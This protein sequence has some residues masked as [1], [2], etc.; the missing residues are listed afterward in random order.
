MKGAII[1]DVCGSVYEFSPPNG[2]NFKLFSIHSQFT[3]DTV[4]TIAIADALLNKKSFKSVLREYG[5]RYKTSYGASFHR[6]LK[7]EDSSPY[8]SYGNGSAMRVSPVAY[9]A[10]DEEHLLDLAKQTA[11]VTH[12]HKEGIKGAQAVAL[13]I[14]L[15]LH[16]Y[17]KED[18]KKRIENKFKYDLSRTVAKIAPTYRFSEICQKTVPEAICCFLD[19]HSYESAI[20][21]AIGIGGDADTLAC[22]TGSI[23]EAYY[24]KLPY[25]LSENALGLLPDEFHKII[26]QF[27]EHSTTPITYI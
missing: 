18:I 15:S 9:F 26:K 22:I 3:D 12:N 10:T 11:E 21:N 27:Y 13:A 1:G 2:F 25:T 20:R 4:L 5:N 8:N 6:W 19:S 24:K 14:Y 23:A 7:D 17:T 16:G